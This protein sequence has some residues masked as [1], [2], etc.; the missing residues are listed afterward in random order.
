MIRCI[1]LIGLLLHFLLPCVKSYWRATILSP[2]LISNGRM[3]SSLHK[4][5]LTSSSS[6]SSSISN[7]SQPIKGSRI[8]E[9]QAQLAKAGQAGLLSYGI[10]NCA[11]YISLT[12]FV[13]YWTGAG[14]STTE[15]GRSSLQ[16]TL[17]RLGKVSL[18][19]WLGSQA[20]KLFR[21]L[22]AVAMAP[23]ADRLIDSIQKR[24]Q[25]KD[26]NQSFL[27]LVYGLWILAGSFYGSIVL[28]GSLL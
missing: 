1:V 9:L 20:T 22:G 15:V 10:L 28:I 16:R 25:L 19:V 5:P 21:L 8:K 4:L 13:W 27:Y 17:T 3:I 6:I 26:R 2:Q 12:S 7:S 18:T 24:F 23:I 14:I 11:Y